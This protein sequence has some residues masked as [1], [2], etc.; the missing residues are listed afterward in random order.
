M[1][2][3]SGHSLTPERRIPLR[4][5]QLSLKE[6]E[7]TATIVPEDMTGI[8]VNSW[9][10]DDSRPGNGIV[11]RVKSIKQSFDS[12]TFTISLEHVINSLRDVIC[13]GEAKPDKIT[14]KKSATKCT[15][16]EAVNFVLGLQKDWVLGSFSFSDV[17]NPYKFDGDTVFDCIETVTNSLEGARWTYD[18]SSYPFKLNIIRLNDEVNSEL[19]AGRN[20]RTIS[21][22]IDKSGM[23]TRFY[24]IGKADLHVTGNYVEKNTKAYGVISKTDTDQT[25]ETE[26][27]LIRWANERLRI[28]AEPTVTIDIDGLELADATG[29]DLDRLTLGRICRVPLPEFET[30]IQERVAALNYPDKVN[31]PASV[32][33]TLANNR[34]DVT[35]ILAEAARKGGGG[36]RAA[37]RDEKEK[38]A[39]IENTNDH[40]ALCAKGIIGVDAKGNPNWTR[41]SEVVVDGE[42][43]HQRVESTREDV[44]EAW[45]KIDQNENAIT[46]EAKRAVNKESSLESQIKVAADRIGLVVTKKQGKDVIDTASIVLGINNDADGGGSYIKLKAKTVDLGNY[47]TVGK[48]TALEGDFKNLT[49]GRASAI[50]L[51]VQTLTAYTYKLKDEYLTLQNVTVGGHTYR[52]LGRYS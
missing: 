5:M 6:R 42:G 30:V 21:K 40:V 12:R 14:G 45:T 22:S 11:W 10:Q 52:L 27:E 43:I 37:A 4:S 3:L 39:W 31:Q 17:S 44:K 2:L 41:M 28:H 25:I 1:I 8:T 33:I 23:Y 7:S 47:A 34:Q 16:K 38:M 13:F 15:A 20:L 36:G 9:M 26:A 48:L 19:R 29:E 35:K 50:A 46:I 18:F 24:P 51:R 32:R 49:S